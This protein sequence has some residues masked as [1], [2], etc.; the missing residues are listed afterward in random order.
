M[1]CTINER[2]EKSLYRM[3]KHQIKGFIVV[4]LISSLFMKAAS[5]RFRDVEGMFIFASIFFSALFVLLGLIIPIRTIFFLGRTIESIEFVGNDLLISTPQV[6]WV[7]S[8]S[9]VL[10][11]D[12]VRHTKQKFPI[13]ENKQLAGLVLQDRSTNKRYHL[14]EVFV[15]DFEEVMSRISEN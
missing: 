2:G 10:S 11:L 8:K 15:D 5:I 6:L 13:Y 1:K 9:I 4:L 7:K 14:V 12:Q 3:M